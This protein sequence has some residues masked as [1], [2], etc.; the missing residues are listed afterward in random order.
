MA[1]YMYPV[2]VVLSGVTYGNEPRRLGEKPSAYRFSVP[3]CV[4]TDSEIPDVAGAAELLKV[5]ARRCEAWSKR[6]SFRVL[7]SVP[8]CGSTTSA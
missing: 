5:L 1:I 2:L 3:G 8:G 4:D 7:E 6:T